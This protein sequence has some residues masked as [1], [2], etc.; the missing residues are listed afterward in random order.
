VATCVEWHNTA[1]TCAEWHNTIAT[2]AEWHNTTATCAEWH[3]TAAKCAEWYNTAATCAQWHN[4]AATLPLQMTTFVHRRR[5][6]IMLGCRRLAEGVVT[7]RTASNFVSE[8]WFQYY[9]TL[10]EHHRKGKADPQHDTPCAEHPLYR[11]P[12]ASWSSAGPRTAVPVVYATVGSTWST[13]TVKHRHLW[14][15]SWN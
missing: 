1:A 4:T 11:N 7:L 15:W 13:T 6:L 2:C 3:N 12:T 14:Q 5:F 10:F 9:L 8:T